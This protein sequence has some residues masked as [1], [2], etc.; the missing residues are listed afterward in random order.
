M[1]KNYLIL[2]L[3]QIIFLLN[4]SA[5]NSSVLSSGNW[6]KISTNQNGIY[7]LDYTDF[8]ALG[9]GVANI[10]VSDIKLYGNGG[11]MLPRLNSQARHL[12][13]V[14][15]AI[16][17]YDSNNNGFFENGDYILFYGMSPNIWDFNTNTNLFEQKTH[18]FSDEVNYFLTINNHSNGRRIV[19]K[20]ILLNPTKVITDYNAYAYHELELENLLKSGNKWFGESFSYDKKQSFSFSFPNLM[21]SDYINMKVAVAARSYGPSSFKIDVNPSFSLN[22]NVPVLSPLNTSQF[23]YEASSIDQFLVNS[24]NLSVDIEYESLDDQAESWLDYIELNVRRKLRL[25]SSYF[26][27]RDVEQL[28]DY[29]GE[30]RIENGMNTQVWDVTDPANIRRLPTVIDGDVLLFNDSLNI[31]HEYIAFNTSAYLTPILKGG[32]T[33]Q[34]LHGASNTIEFIIVSHPNF[35]LEAHRLADFHLEKDNIISIVVTPQQIYNEFSSGMQDVSAIRDFVKYQYDKENSNL[36]YLLLFGDGSFDPKNRTQDNTNFIITYQS[37]N[38]INKSQSYITDDY[39]GLLDDSEGLFNNDLIDIGIGRLPASSVAE[40]KVLVDKIE[41]YYNYST[42]GSWRNNITF[43]ADDGDAHDGNIHMTQANN[44]ANIISEDYGNFNIQKIY[45][46]NYYQESTPGGNRSPDAKDAISNSV[47]KGSLLVNYTG[48]GGELGWTNERI[49]EIQ[50]INEW[51]NL[52]NMPLFMTATCNFSHFDNPQ[53]KSAGEHLLLNPEGGAIALLSTTR[54][55]YSGQNYDLNK[56]FIRTVFEKQDGEFQR[57]GDIFQMTKDSV[58]DPYHIN[59]RNFI[60]L[61]DPALRLSYPEFDIETTVINDTLKALGQ[62]EIQGNIT[63]DGLF[64]SNFNGTLYSTI[65][66]KEIT[67]VTLGQESC[68]PMPYSDQNNILYKGSASIINGQF[69]FSFIVPKDIDYNYGAGK[70]SYYAVN[71]NEDNPVDA[72]GSDTTFKIGGTAQD[73][74][75]DYDPAELSLYMNDTIFV[76][77]GITDE[78]PI[79]IVDIFDLSGINTVG[80]GIGHDITAV[81]DANTA[82]P[83][84]LNDFYESKKDDFTKGRIIFPFYNLEK[85]VHSITVKVWEVFNN[86]SEGIIN[87]VVTDGDNLVVD[88]FIAYP[89]PFSVSTDIYF[90]HNQDNQEFDYMLEFYSITGLLVKRIQKKSYNSDGYRIGPIRWDGRDDYGAKLAGGIYFANLSV[91]LQNGE[92]FSK[93]I[94]IILLP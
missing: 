47:I 66:D 78:N 49:L 39:F 45:L 76:D 87:F 34:N 31:L 53:T 86:S 18:L 3:F 48:H 81:L 15:N 75:Y 26:N 62:V 33:N 63:D 92:F 93:S 65:Y 52:D 12:D 80:N 22:L 44:L 24:S 82:N 74:I 14:E 60:L 50:Q 20:N 17:I 55:V 68:E 56:E 77:G 25:S 83:Y 94:R 6:Y 5:Q 19:E 71:N 35:L 90:Q 88:D 16:H 73:I 11:G 10:P 91:N 21:Q 9:V 46:D 2:L 67:R 72:S 42:F 61:G 59:H 70:I 8:Q 28:G 36:K 54:L 85:G 89:N 57:L 29:I 1:M 51:N 37:D 7:K 79:L 40:A 38:S 43:V 69:A 41:Y 13:L 58:I 23:A 64:L 32:V 84:V 30:Y 4:L 27:F